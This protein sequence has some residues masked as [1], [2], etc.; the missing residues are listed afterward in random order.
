M[1]LLVI[2]LLLAG[3]IVATVYRIYVAIIQDHQNNVLNK[4]E[5]KVQQDLEKDAQDA[6][7]IQTAD[8]ALNS[9]IDKFNRDD[10]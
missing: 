2:K 6:K 7:D 1:T 8:E 10:K 9:A 3:G 5:Q 4:A